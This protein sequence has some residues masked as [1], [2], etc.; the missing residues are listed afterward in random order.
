[1]VYPVEAVTARVVR[2][3]P[4]AV[5]PSKVPLVAVALEAVVP[6]RDPVVA[7]IVRVVDEPIYLVA[8]A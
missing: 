4:V 7:G 1:M 6:L 3:V 8:R 5:A 2:L